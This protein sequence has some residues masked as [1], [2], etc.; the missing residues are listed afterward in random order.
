MKRNPY[1]FRRGAVL[2]Y[3]FYMMI[4]MMAIASLAVDYGRREM[5]KT[6]MQRCADATAHAALERYIQN[7]DTF[8]SKTYLKTTFADYEPIDA[9]SG[10]SPTVSVN[11]GTWNTTTK[12]FTNN[13][14]PSTGNLQAVKI[15]VS[16]TQANSNAI[17]LTF[18]LPSSGKSW[19][20]SSLRS[21]CLFNRRIESPGHRD[22]N[23]LRPVQPLALRHARRLIAELWRLDSR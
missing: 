14:S 1:P 5:I 13:G 7:N 4:I 12:S 18:P 20:R 10:V 15:V 8:D 11:F 6:E 16:R 21:V 23:R 22:R 2:L 3:S 19:I 9:N 17:P